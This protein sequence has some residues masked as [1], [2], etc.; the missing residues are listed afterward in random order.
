VPQ[1]DHCATGVV[2]EPRERLHGGIHL[3][4]VVRVDVAVNR[5]HQ[6]VEGDKP[7]FWR[8]TSAATDACEDLAQ[9]GQLSA[10]WT[11]IQQ[12]TNGVHIGGSASVLPDF[13]HHSA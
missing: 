13:L 11:G 8:L 6:R 4:V 1:L 2:C 7:T 10:P 9:Y 3:A 12:I 5:R